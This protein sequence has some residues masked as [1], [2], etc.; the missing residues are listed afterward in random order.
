M[1]IQ[2][3]TKSVFGL[4]LALGMVHFCSRWLPDNRVLGD[5]RDIADDQTDARPALFSAAGLTEPRSRTVQIVCEIAGRIETIRVKAGDTVKKG[6]LLAEV[7][8]E[9]QSSQLDL[10]RAG[11]DRAV[12]EL[13]RLK[14]GERAEDREIFK[15]Q[16][17]EAEALL[18]VAESEWQRV[19]KIRSE[20][21]ATDRELAQYEST[22]DQAAARQRMAQMRLNLVEAGPRPEDVQRAEA[23]VR[24]AK[25][26]FSAAESLL[27]RTYIRA[28]M[29]GIVVYRYLEPG[30][31]VS[32][33]TPTPI[34]SIGDRTRLH[35][36]VDVDEM[37]IGQI[38]KGQEVYGL[39]S[40]FG[41]RRFKGHVVHIEPTLG[42]KNFRT[43]RPTEKV[44][45][46]VQEVVVE[47]DD[48]DE[49]PLELQMDVWFLNHPDR[50]GTSTGRIAAARPVPPPGE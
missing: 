49:V 42:R 23:A 16:L 9:L 21:A 12:A 35:V 11:V 15:A 22:R 34:M 33:Q 40:A 50:Q 14:N 24:E 27:A 8:H 7:N 38:W 48:A 32:T 19:G 28:P 47:L 45:T 6:D 4:A 18:R 44:D 26:Q 29:D 43:D 13:T 46:R 25:A 31:T 37:D 17:E 36:R 5:S 3:L 20:D 30:E 2:R 1:V 41:E 39:A 10:A